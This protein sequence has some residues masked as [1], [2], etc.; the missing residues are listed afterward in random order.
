MP[1]DGAIGRVFTPYCPRDRQNNSKKHFHEKNAPTLLAVFDG[2]GSAPIPYC[3]YCLIEEV[4][5][6]TRIHC[7]P[8]LG[9]HLIRDHQSDMPM[10]FYVWCFYRQ[11]VKKGQKV[12][13]WPLLT[14]G[15]V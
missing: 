7:M 1:L 2:H 5:S 15:L 6:F 14:I 13:G 8:P 9:N 4:Q 12:K 11:I 10:F 3:T